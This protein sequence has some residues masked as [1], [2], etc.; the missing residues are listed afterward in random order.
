M[1]K[2]EKTKHIHSDKKPV[3]GFLGLLVG[4]GKIIREQEE[5]FWSL[6]I[7]DFKII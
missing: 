7:F 2:I 5:M 4:I 3:C 6:S 1:K